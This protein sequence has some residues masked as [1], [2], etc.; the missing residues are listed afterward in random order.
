MPN[1]E[2]ITAQ[3]DMGLDAP[4]SIGPAGQAV[5]TCACLFLVMGM[6]SFSVVLP[7]VAAAF[8]GNAGSALLAQLIGTAVGLAF[9]F[10]SPV[11]GTLVDRHGYKL[12]LMW[13]ALGFAVAGTSV[14]FLNSLYLILASRILLGIAVGGTQVAALA[15]IATFPDRARARA[16]GRFTLASG[17]LSVSCVFIISHLATIGW[18][19]PFLLHLT[20]LLA[21]PFI[22]FLLPAH[23]A[24]PAKP[25]A[26]RVPGWR[27]LPARFLLLTCFV[28]MI[29]FI[30]ALFGPFYL[31]SIGVNDPA[32]LGVPMMVQSAVALSGAAT[33]AWLQERVGIAGVWAVALLFVGAGFLA[34][35]FS[36]SLLALTVSLAIAGIGSTLCFPN[37]SASAVSIASRSHGRALAFANGTLFGAPILLPFVA[38]A[39]NKAFGPAAV[40]RLYGVAAALVAAGFLL[41]RAVR[42]RA[43]PRP[44]GT[45]PSG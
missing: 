12:V 36:H 1:S 4:P 21:I 18:R 34:A 23:V 2:A 44:S 20:G 26:E 28:G 33:Y 30:P 19:I 16:L 10:A 35:G 7:L 5:L 8:P 25:D 29:N 31:K 11:I 24:P 41:S 22:Y 9:A 32:L 45:S 40:F 42:Q 38:H 27:V 39:L 14:V 37:V 43:L 3:H 17:I 13:S 15:G 6:F